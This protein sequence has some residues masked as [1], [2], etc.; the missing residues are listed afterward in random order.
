MYLKYFNVEVSVFYIFNIYWSMGDAI[1]KQFSCFSSLLDKVFILDFL[2]LWVISGAYAHTKIF[3]IRYFSY[4]DHQKFS[5]PKK[6]S[7][8]ITRKYLITA[9]SKIT[10]H[11][12]GPQTLRYHGTII[13]YLINISMSKLFLVLTVSE[14]S[15]CKLHFGFDKMYPSEQLRCFN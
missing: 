15:P 6:F 12:F 11:I 10:W 1:P 8:Y 3:Q 5:V 7:R 4:E 14:G 2:Q 13:F 9:Q